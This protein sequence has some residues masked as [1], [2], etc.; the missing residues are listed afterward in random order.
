MGVVC[1]PQYTTAE[2][3]LQRLA[4]HVP[5]GGR[6]LS[7]AAVERGLRAPT[8]HRTPITAAV[9]S[10]ANA[11]NLVQRPSPW[12]ACR[13]SRT[14]AGYQQ[15]RSIPRAPPESWRKTGL[16]LMNSSTADGKII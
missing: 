15:A 14:A 7:Q 3:H 4:M 16:V 9:S 12:P 2:P 8:R 5:R 10:G 13:R 11:I 1:L 6:A